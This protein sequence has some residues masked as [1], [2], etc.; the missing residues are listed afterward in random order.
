[1]FWLLV[2]NR[3]MSPASHYRAQADL[4]RRLAEITVQPNL[5]R[6]LCYVAEE[7]DHLANEIAGHD[8]DIRHLEALEP[9]D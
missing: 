7:L 1:M 2:F 8:T 3:G 4:A 6:E 5:Q 9:R